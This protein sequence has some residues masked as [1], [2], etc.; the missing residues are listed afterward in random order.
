[1]P[2][3]AHDNY[4]REV[5]KCFVL[6]SGG[7]DSTTALAIAADEFPN[8]EID[9]VTID[10]G[11]RH[12]KEAACAAQQARNYEANHVTLNAKGLL[13]GM[14]VDKGAANE[15]IPQTSYA[16]LPSGISPTYVSFRNGMMLS[17]LA[18]RAQSWVMAEEAQGQHIKATATIYAGIHADDAAR[19]AYPDCTLEFAGAMANAIYVGTY[20]KVRLRVPLVHMAKPDVVAKGHELG[21]AYHDTWSCYV[22]ADEHCGVCPTC[23]ARKEAFELAGVLDPTTY[24]E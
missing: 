13:T 19:D 15:D 5:H 10:Y 14:L 22:G 12:L 20:F 8:S 18:A 21:V 23:R 9:C 24:T 16:E 6:L 7:I 4:Q 3:N 1:M 17:L 11:Q 2:K